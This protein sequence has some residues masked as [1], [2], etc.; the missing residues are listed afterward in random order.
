MEPATD[1]EQG[2]RRAAPEAVL[3]VH[4]FRDQLT[5][6]LRREHAKRL[7]GFMRDD[8]GLRFA[9]LSD[10]SGVDV[11]EL[12]RAWRFEVVYHL[13]SFDHNRRVR[14]KTAV[15]GD[16]PWTDSVVDLWKGAIWQ[17][18]EVFDLLG[19]GFRGHPDLRRILLPDDFAD[20]PLRRDYPL[21]GKGERENFPVLGKPRPRDFVPL[22]AAAKEPN[23]GH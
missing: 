1:I 6:T 13:V 17:E 20:H 10:L 3:D 9:F 16:D 4:R 7:L 19:V 22:F 18:R 2:L 5:I 14:I 15:P 8:A 21:R 11:V 23:A 12:G